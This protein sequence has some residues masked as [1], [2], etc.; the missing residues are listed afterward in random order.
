MKTTIRK[1]V[2]E[3]NSS[4]SHV[5]V[6]PRNSE[7][8]ESKTDLEKLDWTIKLTSDNTW[9]ASIMGSGDHCYDVRDKLVYIWTA[10]CSGIELGETWAYEAADTL[11]KVVP[12]VKLVRP[13]DKAFKEDKLNWINHQSAEVCGLKKIFGFYDEELKYKL[14]RDLLLHGTIFLN[15]EE[16]SMEYDG[17]YDIVWEM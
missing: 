9:E 8:K 16:N 13:K 12:N 7:R 14:L 3:T 11:Q 15:Y 5:L 4:S 10:I 1:G 6:I 2:F 17:T